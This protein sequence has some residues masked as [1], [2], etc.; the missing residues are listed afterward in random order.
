MNISKLKLK[1][2][3]A[4]NDRENISTHTKGETRESIESA[5]NLL[6]SGEVRVAEK[7]NGNWIINEWLKKVKF[8]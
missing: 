4:W 6:D 7:I 5:L 1:I 3:D 2:E 8:G